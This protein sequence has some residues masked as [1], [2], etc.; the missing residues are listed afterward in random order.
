M[1]AAQP[2]GVRRRLLHP[3][4]P[5]AALGVLVLVG[6]AAALRGTAGSGALLACAAGC[7]AGFANSGST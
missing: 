2:G 3:L 6:A 1:T 7:V 5:A 4:T